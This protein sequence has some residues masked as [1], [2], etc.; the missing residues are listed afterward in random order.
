[1]D[2]FFET[3]EYPKIALKFFEKTDIPGNYLYWWH[4]EEVTKYNSHGLFP[5]TKEKQQDF[6]NQIENGSNIV[7]AV[8]GFIKMCA[9]NNIIE[10]IMKK[11]GPGWVHIGNI[12]LNNIDW[13]YKSA[14]FACV[15][16]EKEFWNK[17]ICTKAATKLYDHGF[18][19]LNLHRIWTGTASTN[20]GM[21]KVALKLGMK[22]EGEFK[23]GMFL[24]GQYV[25]VFSYG[26]L[27]DQWNNNNK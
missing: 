5:Y 8:Y 19:K 26:I 13:V 27:K 15:F 14:E 2:F 25:D 12:S 11:P 10:K 21:Q 23:D 4:D 9:D 16:G 24:N 1:M 20:I 18:N 6:L 17:G 22:K 7:W 3:K